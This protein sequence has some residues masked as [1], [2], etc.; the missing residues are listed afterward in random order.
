MLFLHRGRLDSEKATDDHHSQA[1]GD[2]EERLQQLTQT[3][4]PRPRA[5]VLRDRPRHASGAGESSG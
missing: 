5:A 1:A 4:T 3:G 2:A